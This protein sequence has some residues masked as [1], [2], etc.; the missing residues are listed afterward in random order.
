MKTKVFGTLIVLALCLSLAAAIATGPAS[1][2]LATPFSTPQAIVSGVSSYGYF[3]GGDVDIAIDSAGNWHAVY[4]RYLDMSSG[5]YIMYATSGSAPVALAHTD[6]TD[7]MTEGPFTVSGPSIAVDQADNVHVAYCLHDEEDSTFDVMYIN[8]VLGSW[9]DPQA[10]VSGEYRYATGGR[11]EVDIAID[12][13]GNWHVVYTRHQYMSWGAYIMYA[14]SGSAPV[15]LAHTD[16]TDDMTEGPFT[17]SMPSIAVD[18]A[19]N[20]HVAYCLYDEEATTFDVMYINN[21]LGSWSDP[22][23][24]VS[25]EYPYGTGRKGEVDIAIDLAGNWHVVYTRYPYASLGSSIMYAT[26]GSGPVALATSQHDAS[27]PSIAVDQ[28]GNA[29][30]AY[31]LNYGT[32][33]VMY[34]YLTDSLPVPVPLSPT[35][36]K[37]INSSCLLDW[38]DVADTSGVFYQIRLYDSSWSKI[39][40]ESQ[41]TDSEF[42]VSSFGSLADGTYYWKVRAVAGAGYASAWT[43]AWAFKL[44]NTPPP[45]PSLVSPANWKWI[46]SSYS[47]DWSDISDP[48]G[49]T[50]QVRLYNSSWYLV[51]EKTGLIST[52][53]ALSSFGSLA[54]GTYYWKVRAVD[55]PGNASAWTTSKAFKLDNTPPPIPSLVSPAN[56]K[57]VNSTYKLDWSD[58]SDASGVTYQVWLYDSFWSLVK[59]KTG[60][61]S[62]NCA[63]SSLGALADG[64]Y[65]WRVLALDGA[66]NPSLLTTSRAIKLDNTPPP[67]PSVISPANWKQ[68]NSSATLDWADV[69]DPS[70]VT[71]QLRLYSSSW[72]LVSD[73]SGL[74][75]SACP[76]GF[77]GSL[78]DGT[79]YWKIR[80]VD[81][82]G[83]ASAWTTSWAFKR[84]NTIPPLPSLLSPGDGTTT[85][86]TPTLDWSDV[87]DASGVTYELQVDNDADFS[88]PGEGSLSASE[89]TLTA[90]QALPSGTYYWRVRAVD[91]AGNASTWTTAW[92]FTV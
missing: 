89:Y 49:V 71:Y 43:T 75:S 3:E 81:G 50:Y 28:T 16:G 73:N 42:T 61:T 45:M 27:M 54:D 91:G 62:S 88:S 76:L 6:G 74:T 13:A 59:G 21:V 79:Y 38:S 47:L 77:F 24:I 10:I 87:T 22:Q 90:E 66:G 69:T 60:L 64:T 84:D 92:S 85:T 15:A 29:H 14:T 51:R 19:D 35:S 72:V 57:K 32:Y 52:T 46:N 70:G 2:V 55:G 7:D 53:C 30:V 44:D 31:C 63:V 25:G 78:A 17:V 41:L 56:W 80:A 1:L 65:Y 8:N 11:G 9:S 12:S 39:W 23:A 48:S 58:V 37:K 18:Q 20:T 82:A 26:S 34:T 40:D 67:I 83:N 68:V 86:S 33:S 36:W 4:T 5:A